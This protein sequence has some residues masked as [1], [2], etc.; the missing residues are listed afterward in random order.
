VQP[1][2]VAS[3]EASSPGQPAPVATTE[4][5]KNEEE[6]Q[7]AALANTGLPVAPSSLTDEAATSLL[8]GWLLAWSA[9]DEEAYFS[10]YAPDFI[11]KDLN[12]RLSSFKR[13]RR[14]RF[15]EAGNIS[16]EA[17]DTKV[18]VSGDKATITFTQSYQSDRHSDRGLKTLE[19]RASD[20]HWLISSESFQ[21]RP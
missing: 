4:A 21:D 12:L 19:L 8:E 18:A 2:P 9:K 7:V 11:F 3:T 14:Q 10:Y 6:T 16:V 1:A 20:G 15:M 5:S 17:S 13:Y